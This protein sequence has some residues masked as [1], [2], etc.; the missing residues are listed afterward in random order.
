[1]QPRYNTRELK[2]HD[3]SMVRW[4]YMLHVRGMRCTAAGKGEK[5]K[6]NETFGKNYQQKKNQ[7]DS[8]SIL[9]VIHTHPLILATE[10]CRKVLALHCGSFIQGVSTCAYVTCGSIYFIS[11]T[12]EK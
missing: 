8:P 5:R 1:M 4:V 11:S 3:R 9:F 2:E 7:V 6:E 12:S 10:R